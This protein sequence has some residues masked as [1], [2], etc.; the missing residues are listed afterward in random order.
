M[1]QCLAG[2]SFKSENFSHYYFAQFAKPTEDKRM[3]VF[4]CKEC[5]VALCKPTLRKNLKTISPAE[6][7]E[8]LKQ[9][10]LSTRVTSNFIVMNVEEQ[11]KSM[12]SDSDI[13]DIVAKKSLDARKSISSKRSEINDVHDGK[14]YKK[15]KFIKNSKKE[16]IVLTANI[17]CDGAAMYETSKFSLWPI[18]MMI[19]ELP[20]NV[21]SK[22]TL[23]TAALFTQKEPDIKLMDLFMKSLL[24]QMKP[25][26][27]RGFKILNKNSNVIVRVFLI[28]LFFVL[29]S[30]ARPIV[31]ARVKL[32]DTLG[33]IGATYM[34]FI[35]KKI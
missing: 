26:I 28:P 5:N 35:T 22:M 33:A 2:P 10:P 32:M 12:L 4:Y 15:N 9:Y 17:N 14:L 1:V 24:E 21:R 11:L 25:L 20:F 18:L 30:V 6:C 23:L 8:C 34:A 27:N 7:K 31:A 29:D 13:L 19:N 16:D 3:Y